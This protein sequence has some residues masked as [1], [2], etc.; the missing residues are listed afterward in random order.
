[1]AK[2]AFTEDDDALLAELGVEVE[3]KKV[4]SRTPKEERIIAG[5]EEI[6]RFVEQ[7]GRMPSMA[8]GNDI[9]ERIYAT[10]LDQIRRQRECRD[11][12]GDL[13]HQGLL[14]GAT[15]EQEHPAEDMSDDELLAELGVAVPAEDDVT[16]L[17]HVKSRAECLSGKLTVFL[18]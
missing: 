14:D 6:Q 2:S 16:T 12:V 15:I 13:D 3:V 11:V 18:E 1:M 8:E 10:R 7:S 5:F 4:A 9:F 17:R